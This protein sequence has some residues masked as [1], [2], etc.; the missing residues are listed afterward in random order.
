MV[1]SITNP[2]VRE[3]LCV[4]EIRPRLLLDWIPQFSLRVK[5]SMPLRAVMLN[6]NNHRAES[7]LRHLLLV[8]RQEGLCQHTNMCSCFLTGCFRESEGPIENIRPSPGVDAVFSSKHPVTWSDAT[9]ENDKISCR[10]QPLIALE[11]R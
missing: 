2:E 11:F 10:D 4:L 8:L 7:V 9:Q 5:R 1:D 3:V 6:E